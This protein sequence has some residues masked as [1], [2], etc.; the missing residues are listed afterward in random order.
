MYIQ[1]QQKIKYINWTNNK[2]KLKRN[3]PP[4]IQLPTNQN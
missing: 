1:Q 3:A 2:L 4:R